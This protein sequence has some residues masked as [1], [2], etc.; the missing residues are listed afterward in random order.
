MGLVQCMGEGLGFG[1]LGAGRAV[2]VKRVADEEDF[3]FVLADE[4]GDGFE[5]GTERGAMEGE[6]RLGGETEGVG[7]GEADAA[8]ADV[9]RESAGVRHGV[10]VRARPSV[11]GRVKRAEGGAGE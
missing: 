5:I 11:E 10:S 1:G 7:D 3:D 9:E 8:V 2:G 4:A 6:E